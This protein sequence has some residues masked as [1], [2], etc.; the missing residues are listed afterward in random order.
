MP[1]YEHEPD[2]AVLTESEQQVKKP[3]LYKVLLHNDDYTTM[4]F[5]VFVLET[6]FNLNTNEA[7]RIML[8]VH[9]QGLGIAGVYT[10]E[11]AETKVTKVEQLA[12]EHEYPLLC[13][14]EEE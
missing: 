11:I 5:V 9:N 13:T 3:P 8:Q 4:E 1:D 7:I 12:E 6:I 2:E 10:Y 14:M